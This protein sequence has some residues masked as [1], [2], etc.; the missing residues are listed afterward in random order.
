MTEKRREEMRR[1]K[2]QAIITEKKLKER[3]VNNITFQITRPSTTTTSSNSKESTALLQKQLIPEVVPTSAISPNLVDVRSPLFSPSGAG[4]PVTST[5]R[6]RRTYSKEKLILQEEKSRIDVQPQDSTDV[7]FLREMET[8]VPK[9]DFDK[10]MSSVPSVD[11]NASTGSYD[12]DEEKVDADER[13]DSDSCSHQSEDNFAS[14]ASST[15]TFVIKRSSDNK[16]SENSLRKTPLIETSSEEEQE[17]GKNCPPPT[18]IRKPSVDDQ[19]FKRKR[20]AKYFDLDD[21]EEDVDKSKC[22][23]STFS[24]IPNHVPGNQSENYTTSLVADST[25]TSSKFSPVPVTNFSLIAKSLTIEFTKKFCSTSEFSSTQTTAQR[26]DNSNSKY[27]NSGGS[28][29]V[30]LSKDIPSSA[31]EDIKAGDDDVISNSSDKENINSSGNNTQHVRKLSYTLANPSAALLEAYSKSNDKPFAQTLD[32]V[33]SVPS[34]VGIQSA[35]PTPEKS[36]LRG[37][38]DASLNS[39]NLSEMCLSKQA[40]LERFLGEQENFGKSAPLASNISPPAAHVAQEMQ[41]ILKKMQEEYEAQMR[42]LA[43]QHRMQELKMKKEF[44]SEMEKLK[45]KFSS[46]LNTTD[47]SRSLYK[48]SPNSLVDSVTSARSN[49]NASEMKSPLFPTSTCEDSTVNTTNSGRATASHQSLASQSIKIKESSVFHFTGGGESQSSS[50]TTFINSTHHG[51]PCELTGVG[52]SKLQ[53]RMQLMSPKMFRT[54][55]DARSPLL[56]GLVFLDPLDK[57]NKPLR[58]PQKVSKS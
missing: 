31:E 2:E 23:T 53:S 10:S 13:N 29:D 41:D 24:S 37:A 17:N 50:T 49:A 34:S 58:I 39:R 3:R 26:M 56:K 11:D 12:G 48:T 51:G 30:R 55:V 52:L 40:H 36:S 38:G 20:P 4:V 14:A 32:T 15:G 8:A 57:P 28:Y 16:S 21:E 18:V 54:P 42:H 35:Q 19:G 7:G 47:S 43:E 33:P 27:R 22:S 25:G 9:F 46:T 44:E 1:Y 5:P 6:P 45:D